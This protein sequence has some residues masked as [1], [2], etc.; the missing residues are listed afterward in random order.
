MVGSLPVP[1][2][3]E[4]AEDQLPDLVKAG[5]SAAVRPRGGVRRVVKPRSGV[6]ERSPVQGVR[7]ERHCLRTKAFLPNGLCQARA[8]GY[9]LHP[10]IRLSRYSYHPRPL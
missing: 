5:V 2:M 8:W 10:D 1:A 6:K 4:P 3:L 9:R 7:S